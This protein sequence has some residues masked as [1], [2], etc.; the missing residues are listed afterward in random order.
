MEDSL[1]KPVDPLKPVA[2]YGFQDCSDRLLSQRVLCGGAPQPRSFGF[3]LFCPLVSKCESFNVLEVDV[4]QLVV[5]PE[6]V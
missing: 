5:R 3:A 1:G 4:G 2:W 6:M